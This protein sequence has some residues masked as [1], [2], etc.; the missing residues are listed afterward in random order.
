MRVFKILGI[1]REKI[2]SN[3]AVDADRAILNSCL[4]SCLR[5]FR[6]E[7]KLD[8]EIHSIEGE[9]VAGAENIFQN[10]LIL[11]MAQ[12]SDVLSLLEKAEEMGVTVINSVRSIKNCYRLNLSKLLS[13]HNLFY[14]EYSLIDTSVKI[15]KLPFSSWLKRVD[16]HALC[17]EDVVLVRSVEEVNLR[18]Q[19]FSERKV[20]SVILQKHVE[21]EVIKFYGVGDRFFSYRF[22]DR[23]DMDRA[24]KVDKPLSERVLQLIKQTAFRA[25]KVLGLQIYGGDVVLDERENIHLI[26]INDWPSF[27]SCVAEA[28]VVMAQMISAKVNVNS[29]SNSN[30]NLNPLKELNKELNKD[31][32]NSFLCGGV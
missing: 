25:A 23:A 3:R 30:S 1:Y 5:I 22:M 4:N 11:S 27:R 16:F 14:P 12:S 17:D 6:E 9:S 13:N 19:N 32:T 28:S 15:K 20:R 29:N 10:D 18:L 31:V 8:V 21:G 2:Y 7:L 24:D 26:D